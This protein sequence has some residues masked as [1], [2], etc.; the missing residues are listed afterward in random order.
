MLRLSDQDFKRSAKN[1]V[2]GMAV[3]ASQLGIV[4]VANVKTRTSPSSD[5]KGQSVATEFFSDLEVQQIL[6]ELRSSDIFVTPFYD[7]REFMAWILAGGHRHLPVERVLVYNAAQNGTGPGRKSL[8]PAFCGIHGVPIAGSDA[9]VVSLCRHKFHLNRLLRSCGFSVP[10]SWWYLGNGKWALGRQPVQGQSVIVKLTYESASLGL[11]EG[12]VGEWGEQLQKKAQVLTMNFEQPVIVQ[13]F[14][15]G[16]EVECPVVVN[17]DDKWSDAVSIRPNNAAEF[18]TYDMVY[19]DRYT[20][21]AIDPSLVDAEY[22]RAEAINIAELVGFKGIGRVD[23]RLNGER[24]PCVIDIATN[25]HLVDHSSVAYALNRVA[26]GCLPF[27]LLVA[28]K[29]KE[30]GWIQELDQK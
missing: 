30:I 5:Y 16:L 28:L 15:P 25:P 14:M 27:Q 7:E 21:G 19:D 2:A 29:M 3:A 4:V 23:F 10:E 9:Y 6:T 26:P 13:E 12:S 17:Q 11:D 24:R 8:I 20:F 1:L 18:L 22:L